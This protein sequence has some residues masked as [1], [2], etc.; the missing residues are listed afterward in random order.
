MSLKMKNKIFD[1]TI[2]RMTKV[3][4]INPK[5]GAKINVGGKIHNDLIKNKLAFKKGTLTKAGSNLLETTKAGKAKKAKEKRQKA[6]KA[7][8]EAKKKNDEVKKYYSIYIEIDFKLSE[9]EVTRKGTI[10][11]LTKFSDI[12]ASVKAHI[13]RH[14]TDFFSANGIPWQIINIRYKILSTRSKQSGDIA[15]H[16]IKDSS[17]L[18]I[19][20]EG[21]KMFIPKEKDNCLIEYVLKRYPQISTKKI[22][23][24][25]SIPS[26]ENLESFVKKYNIFTRIYN[27]N[28][29]IILSN[30]DELTTTK[31]KP[32][33]ILLFDNHLYPVNNKFLKNNKAKYNEIQYVENVETKLKEFLNNSI[34]PEHISISPKEK[35]TII[36]HIIHDDTLYHQNED[37]DTCK[38]ILK[39]LGLEHKMTVSTN[40]INIGDIIVNLYKHEISLKSVW[41]DF[42]PFMCAGAITYTQDKPKK[43]NINT[44]DINKCYSKALEELDGLLIT[45]DRINKIC[46]YKNKPI[47][48]HNLY[49]VIPD[50]EHP[51]TKIL[52]PTDGYYDGQFIMNTVKNCK[53]KITHIRKCKLVENIYKE[54]VSDL[55]NK[56]DEKTCKTI[57]NVIIGKMLCGLEFRKV[58]KFHGVCNENEKQLHNNTH[59][60]KITDKYYIEYEH[61]NNEYILET[62][63]PI[64]IQVQNKARLLLYNH[65]IK[66]KVDLKDIIQIK[67][68]SF[69][70][71]DRGQKIKNIGTER[72]QLK[73]EVYKP[74]TCDTYETF[75]GVPYMLYE[76][77]FRQ[78]MNYSDA[79]AGK[80]YDIKNNLVPTLDNYKIL[81]PSHSSL[82]EYK[83]NNYNCGVIQYYNYN[84]E[85]PK[86][87]NIIVDECGLLGLKDL[88]SI[89]RMSSA[90]K[91]I[92]MYGDYTQLLPVGSEKQL[93]HGQWIKNYEIAHMKTNYRNHFETKYYDDLRNENIDVIEEVK[94]YN[95]KWEEADKIICFFKKTR[96]EYNKKKMELLNLKFGDIGLNIIATNNK[97]RQLNIYNKF[98]YTI[99]NNENNEY[100][101][102]D[103][104]TEHTINKRQLKNSFIPNYA[105][106]LYSSQ[107]NQYKSYHYPEQDLR[108]IC[109]RSAY[110]LISRL[111]TK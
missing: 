28:K 59:H 54:M 27:K 7:K 43:A 24:L 16:L 52:Y 91:N 60:V 81:T 17:P 88:S 68:D 53:I 80:T 85:V 110:T 94:K 72:G 63:A 64:N 8:D 84:N 14:W 42:Q 38:E 73:R 75:E 56:L 40:L 45:D 32:L 92:Y 39:I 3:K 103:G 47:K 1:N 33:N 12:E 111:K 37:Y 98:S 78:K 70:Y 66:S 97:L 35:G 77:E 13:K 29:E 36:T 21:V 95:T 100:T 69:S 44:Y 25:L 58:L 99:T 30:I 65:I 51:D 79:G 104:K 108:V 15:K 41:Y 106:T 22:K 62:Q 11:V 67:T 18:E 87:D 101:I 23:T 83:T 2:N 74:M 107:G 61:M 49:W 34:L 46:R 82:I 71:I 19:F 31:K 76:D 20:N 90:G 86:E 5:T 102:S 4:V 105:I 96:D 55:Y 9:D 26:L 109:G 57:I 93:N 89:L 48:P 6:K 10:E 50:K